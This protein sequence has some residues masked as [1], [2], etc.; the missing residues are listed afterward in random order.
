MWAHCVHLC[1]SLPHQALVES[2]VVLA[3]APLLS[4]GLQFSTWSIPDFGDPAGPGESAGQARRRQQQAADLVKRLGSQLAECSGLQELHIVGFPPALSLD[5]AV[6]LITV[7]TAQ[8]LRKLTVFVRQSQ[9]AVSSEQ[10]AVAALAAALTA[11]HGSRPNDAPARALHVTTSLV[12]KQGALDVEQALDA[13]DVQ[14]VRVA[15]GDGR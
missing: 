14:G 4:G 2:E 8:Q 1:P 5:L 11:R 6:E 15:Y 7:I 9:H 13:A 12:S 3:L 10:A